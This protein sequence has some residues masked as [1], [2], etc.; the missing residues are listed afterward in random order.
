MGTQNSSKGQDPSTLTMSWY[1]H[2]N[3]GKVNF[4]ISWTMF[5][6]F[7]T[8]PNHNYNYFKMST[9]NTSAELATA[10]VCIIGTMFGFLWFFWNMEVVRPDT[11]NVV[12]TTCYALSTFI[13]AGTATQ[14][15]KIGG[16]THW[17]VG[18]IWGII[19]NSALALIFI[20][21]KWWKQ[22]R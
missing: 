14:I 18:L 15:P 11:V 4:F 5:M 10:V 2:T 21:V 6:W 19:A 20:T 22:G 9:T 3:T 17:Q 1:L 16:Q 7:C 12:L 8:A 13:A